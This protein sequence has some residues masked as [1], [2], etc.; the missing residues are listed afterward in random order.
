[1]PGNSYLSFVAN[2]SCNFANLFQQL[3]FSL[4]VELGVQLFVSQVGSLFNNLL[5]S[6]CL[7]LA[8]HINRIIQYVLLCL[9]F[10]QNEILKFICIADVSIVCYFLKLQ[11][12]VPLY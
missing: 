4:C 10:S 12:S 2:Y 7:F 9:L 6:F 5:H 8:F 11:N 1:M 3:Q